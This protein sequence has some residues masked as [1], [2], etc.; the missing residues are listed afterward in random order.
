MTRSLKGLAWGDVLQAVE[1]AIDEA[2]GDVVESI[3]G[4][5]EVAARTLRE[6][7]SRA[8][9]YWYEG[10]EE[11]Y[12]THFFVHWLHGLAEGSWSLPLRMPRIL[13]EGFNSRHGCVMWRCES[14]MTGLGNGL[15]GQG[16]IGGWSSCPVCGATN[17]SYRSLYEG[18]G[19]EWAY[20][21]LPHTVKARGDS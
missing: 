10:C 5:V 20:K 16:H 13:L 9:P 21:P 19:P 15:I 8:S 17:I 12:E 7:P 3:L 1:A 14:C 11:E 6:A 18:S 2:D 4:H